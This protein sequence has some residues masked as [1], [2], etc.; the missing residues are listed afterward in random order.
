MKHF[1]YLA[2]ALVAASLAGCAA[3][4]AGVKSDAPA[5]S[6]KGVAK[7]VEARAQQRW[8][9]LVAGKAAQAYDYFSPG[10]R[11][12]KDR[13]TYAADMAVRPGH[14]TKAEVQGS[15]CP[16]GLQVCD[17]TVQVYF[18][19]ESTLPGVGTLESFSPIVERWIETEGSWYFVPKE[20][21]RNDRG[22][23]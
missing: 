8:D 20:V 18:T 17:V 22:L 9:L 13:D 21:A 2:A 10:Y 4:P 19:V 7:G 16:K 1:A 15:E 5:A 11:E 3:G 6:P 12:V 14:W 23:R